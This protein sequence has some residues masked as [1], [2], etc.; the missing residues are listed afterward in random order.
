MTKKL[1]RLVIVLLC[2]VLGASMFACGNDDGGNGG[3]TDG[4]VDYNGT[5]N[6]FVPF[7]TFASAALDRVKNA[8]RRLHPETEIKITRGTDSYS[9]AVE[10]IILAPDDSDIDIVQ[11]NVVSQYYGTDKII[12]LTSYLNTRNPYGEQ[13]ASGQYP[14]W[15]NMLEEEAYNMEENAY[16]IPSLSFES[17]YVVMLYNKQLFA[18]NG[19]TEPTNWAEMLALLQSAVDAGYTHPLGLSYDKSSVSS[20]MCGMIIAMYMDQYFRDIIDEA[21]SQDGDYSYVDSLDYDWTF[22][23]NDDTADARSGYTYNMSRLINA[24][25]NTDKYNPESTRFADMMTNLKELLAYSSEEYNGGVTRNFFHNGVLTELTQDNKFSKA[26]TCVLFANRMDYLADFQSSIGS[27][28]KASGEIST[29]VIPTAQLNDYLG[30][31][32]L[33]AMPDNLSVENGAPVSSTLRAFGGPNHHPMG[34][35]NRNNRKRTELA[36][37]FMKFWYSPQGMEEYYSYYSERGLVCP[38][39]ILVKDFELPANIAIDAGVNDAGVCVGNPYLE[40]GMGYNDTIL[41]NEGGTVRDKYIQ[42]I[43]DYL[44]AS[45]M[46][47]SSYGVQLNRNIRSGF[48]KWAEYKNLRVTTW[49]NITDYYKISPFKAKQ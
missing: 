25:F 34:I 44:T 39:K 22:D 20:I 15:K 10:G 7:D 23:P 45:T 12:D 19:W 6:I 9:Q 49:E 16:T 38:L 18:T 3:K 24:Y 2:I 30:W 13:N 29:E 37:D 5:V 48:A 47:W 33:P 27:V 14:V 41:S 8:Y 36:I 28:L 31:F 35:I 17:N 40:I 26:E 1:K 32:P 21:H 42:T 4:G 46:E 43:R 11:I